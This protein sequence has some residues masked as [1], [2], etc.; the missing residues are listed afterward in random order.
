MVT[1]AGVTMSQVAAEHVLYSGRVQGVGF[2]YALHSTARRYPLKGYVKNLA[3]GTV[4][5]MLQGTQA[6]RNDFLSE[7]AGRF[8]NNITDCKR[9]KVDA[10]EEFTVFEIRF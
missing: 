5:L 6:A 3:D 2:R 8:R 9:S 4:E 1:I 10:G 7:V